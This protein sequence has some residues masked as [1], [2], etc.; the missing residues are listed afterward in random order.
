V[1]VKFDPEFSNSQCMAEE[2]IRLARAGN[3]AVI[4]LGAKYFHDGGFEASMGFAT[5]KDEE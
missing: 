4:F 3:L 2:S 1:G 5:P